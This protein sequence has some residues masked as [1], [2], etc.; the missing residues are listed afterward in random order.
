M[1]TKIGLQARCG[2]GRS[3][4]KS[5]FTLI[6]LL[7]VIAI[8]AVLA[9]LGF[10]AYRGVIAKSDSAKSLSQMRGVG[11]ALMTF[12]GE[13]GGIMPS[14]YSDPIRF[15]IYEKPPWVAGTIGKDWH[16]DMWIWALVNTQNLPLQAFTSPQT[17]KQLKSL[18]VGGLPAFMLNQVPMMEAEFANKSFFGAPSRFT[19]PSKT[20]LLSQV[21]FDVST[22][23][24]K[25]QS[26]C[27]YWGDYGILHAVANQKLGIPKTPFVFVDGHAEVL[28]PSETL[29]SEATGDKDTTRWFDPSMFPNTFWANEAACAR[30]LRSRLP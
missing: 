8:L 12:S 28:A 16:N 2:A 4:A 23:G 10:A 17:D 20:I 25:N 29:G 21:G 19:R 3:A 13:N 9:A 14:A 18:G 24:N 15:G 22:A 27:N 1:W 7:V 11:A 26:Y 6:E 30:Y 5:G